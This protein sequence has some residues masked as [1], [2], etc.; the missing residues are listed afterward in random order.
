MRAG[1]SGPLGTFDVT[2]VT[3]YSHDPLAYA[4]HL[5]SLE[6]IWVHRVDPITIDRIKDAD[7]RL[8]FRPLLQISKLDRMPSRVLCM[9]S[10]SW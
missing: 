10:P 4:I 3:T 7:R 1:L 8:P 2:E 6:P 5:I 9:Q